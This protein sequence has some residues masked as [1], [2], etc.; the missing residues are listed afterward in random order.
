MRFKDMLLLAL[1]LLT[2]LLSVT[3]YNVHENKRIREEAE[4]I[5]PEAIRAEIE[6]IGELA[7]AEYRYRDV[8]V[9][10]SSKA[11]GSIPLPFTEKSFILV[12]SGIIKAGTDLES[13]QVEVDAD[14]VRVRLAPSGILSHALDENRTE[15]LYEAD[16]LFNRIRLQE[17][18]DLLREEK[19]AQELAAMS[20][21]LLREADEKARNL[22]RGL[23][24]PLT[25]GRK[26]RVDFY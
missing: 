9:F 26:I 21:G 20:G 24:G 22:I 14:T 4:R 23:L 5:S 8:A 17:Y 3:L 25:G 15:I 6:A 16:G 13:A 1:A 7:A 12:Y 11:L 10:E 19:A 2:A 18:T